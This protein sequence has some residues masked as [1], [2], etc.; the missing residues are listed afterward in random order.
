VNLGMV[1]ADVFVGGRAATATEEDA[2]VEAAA[3]ESGVESGDEE[4]GGDFEF[5]D[6][7][8]MTREGALFISSKISEAILN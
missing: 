5:W 2:G 3:E 8:E 7:S 1:A 6:E 4:T